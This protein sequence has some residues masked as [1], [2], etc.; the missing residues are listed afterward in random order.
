MIT[1]QYV[2]FDTAKMLKEAVFRE[3]CRGLYLPNPKEGK[4]K[5]TLCILGDYDETNDDIYES[6]DYYGYG[7]YYLAPTQ[8]LA[9]RWLRE[10]HKI[11]IIVDVYNKNYYCCNIYQNKHL[12]IIKN[13]VNANY[14]EVLENGLQEALQLI[15]KNKQ[16]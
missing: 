7:D 15:I 1:E 4:Y 14:D 12:M 9:A 16:Q 13:I 5:L 2:S 11:D 10:V 3:P 8:A 6:G